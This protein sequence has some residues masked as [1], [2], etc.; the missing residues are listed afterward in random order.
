MQALWKK[1]TELLITK[2]LRFAKNAT[3]EV[4]TAS[5]T[6]VSIDTNE[7]A[8]L[9]I[10]ARIVNLNVTTTLTRLE[11]AGKFL[12]MGGAGAARTFTLP[13]ATGSG[14]SYHFIVGEVNT[15]NYVIKVADGTDTIDG[16]LLNVDTDTSGALRGFSPGASDDTIT[17]NGTTFGGASIGDY[18]ILRDIAAN[19]WALEGMVSATSAPATGFSNSVS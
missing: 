10:D 6:T 17:L 18:L 7:L 14:A 8:V 2:K 11:H 5:G 12:V 4:T 1:L 16:L 13:A 15:S 9:N 19:Q 3:I